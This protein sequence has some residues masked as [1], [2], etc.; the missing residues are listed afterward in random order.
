[1][2]T[3]VSFTELLREPSPIS[4]GRGDCIISGTAASL[5][6]PF[7]AGAGATVPLLGLIRRLN[8]LRAPFTKLLNPS[9]T[10]R[11]ASRGN[12][13]GLLT[14]LGGVA[15]ACS[16]GCPSGSVM[17]LGG[18]D[19]DGARFLVDVSASIKTQIRN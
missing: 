11:L 6:V 17:G 19:L 2:S 3:D 10:V 16:A 18:C 15:G 4:L 8:K 1:M 12:I 13:V 14:L 5:G 9:R 7:V